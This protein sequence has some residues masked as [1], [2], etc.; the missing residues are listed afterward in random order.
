MLAASAMILN[1]LLNN[2]I[3]PIAH[4]LSVLYG[5]S[6]KVVNLATILSFLIFSFIN[7]PINY[8]LDKKGIKI[9]YRIGLSLFLAGMFFVCLVNVSFPLVIFGYIIFTFGQPF[10]ANTPAKIATYWFFPQNVTE[11]LFLESPCYHYSCR[12]RH[13]R[14][15]F[16]VRHS[17]SDSQRR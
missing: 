12:F 7:I 2:I 5:Q 14:F 3:I 1:G 17:H 9:G 8:F 6:T 11:S 13:Y 10:I 16:G 15:G 4:K